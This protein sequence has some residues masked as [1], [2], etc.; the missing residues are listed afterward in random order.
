MPAN[1]HEGSGMPRVP[2]RRGGMTFR[3]G[4]R[5]EGPG[6]EALRARVEAMGSFDDIINSVRNQVMEVIGG[7]PMTTEWKWF[8]GVKACKVIDI[9]QAA[10]LIHTAMQY[11][12]WHEQGGAG[13][14]LR[15]IN[16]DFDA[17]K[18][19]HARNEFEDAVDRECDCKKIWL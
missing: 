7:G 2:I 9:A 8:E 14:G 11:D 15:Q 17:K 19:W 16:P 12:E 10:G 5:K 1:P 4:E 3:G 13:S 6:A 18:W